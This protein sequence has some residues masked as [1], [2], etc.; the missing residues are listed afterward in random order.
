MLEAV[1]TTGLQPGV[2]FLYREGRGVRSARDQKEAPVLETGVL[3]TFNVDAIKDQ[4]EFGYNFDGYINVPETGVY[5]FWLEA[6]DGAILYINGKLVIDNDGGHREQVL[7]SKIGLKKGWHPIHVD[8]CQNGLAKSLVLEWEG[9]G[10][11]KQ[12]VPAEVLFH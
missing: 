5:T 10:V 9:P 7:D 11:A 8:Y 6:N 1:N 3:S 2:K 12:Q 4:R